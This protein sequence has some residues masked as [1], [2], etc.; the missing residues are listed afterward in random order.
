MARTI[1]YPSHVVAVLAVFFL[2]LPLAE[3]FEIKFGGQIRPRYESIDHKLF[4]GFDSSLGP[5]QIVST[6]MRLNTEFIL[7]ENL[8]AFF[9]LQAVGIWG[10]DASTPLLA[11]SAS[12]LFNAITDVGFHQVYFTVKHLYDI[13]VDLQVGRQEIVLDG[14]RLIGNVG[15]SQSGRI[16]D[17]IRLSH[18]RDNATLLYVMSKTFE[19]FDANDDSDIL[20]HIFW[21][22]YKGLIGDNS[23][24]SLYFIY[25]D[26]GNPNFD[27]AGPPVEQAPESDSDIFT[28]G[29]RQAGS[30]FGID[31]RG[32]FYYQFGQAENYTLQYGFRTGFVGETNPLGYPSVVVPGAPWDAGRNA[33][34]FNAGSGIDRRA[35]MFG[36]RVGKRFSSIPWKPKFT[37]W[38]DHLSGTDQ[39]DINSNVF[40][41]FSTLFA[42]QHKYYGSMDL[43]MVSGNFLAD[44]SL[45]GTGTSTAYLGLRDLA[46]KTSVQPHKKLLLNIDWHWFWTDTDLSDPANAPLATLIGCDCDTNLGQE[47]DITLIH[48][49]NQWLTLSMGYS[50]YFSTALFKKVNSF[51]P[52]ATNLS[53][54]TTPDD[55]DWAFVQLDLNF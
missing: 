47:L 41:T 17:A 18:A 19:G 25:L 34:D 3:A 8:S 6:R 54:P 49:Y 48:R 28:A 26:L 9:Q 46:I 2:W 20:A 35:Y 39:D 1:K 36:I 51:I 45:L 37:V 16:H 31:Y 43:F 52:T 27:R 30:L 11:I 15:W 50:H 5:D 38:Y 21:G 4:T 12:N 53:D 44:P 10:S 13:P 23:S 24:T 55:G 42:T 14:H 22:N 32:E 33:L 7:N 29:L 40:S